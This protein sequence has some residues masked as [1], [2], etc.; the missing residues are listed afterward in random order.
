MLVL[1]SSVLIISCGGN[2]AKNKGNDKDHVNIQSKEVTY[3]SGQDTLKG[4]LYY[5]ANSDEKKPGI[6]VVHEWWGNNEYIQQRAKM[7]AE[8]GYTTFAADMYGNGKIVET[9][10]EANESST[11]VYSNPEILKRRMMA[12]HATLSKD[13]HT[14]SEKIAALGYCF[15][16]TVSLNAAALGVPLDA[17]I[18]FHGGLS[19]FKATPEMKDTKVLVLH[20]GADEFVSEDDVKNFKSQVQEADIQFV[21]K[22]YEEATHAFTNPNATEVGKK[23]NIPIAY[24]ERA[25]KASWQ[26]MKEFLSKH[27]PAEK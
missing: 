1:F 22:Q 14:D 18:S 17:A 8:L 15:G 13:P 2:S 24:N 5:D 26:D 7:L 10:K 9:P 21:F 11:A 25:D 27:F 4:F 19:G 12:A 6:I 16:G 20:G 3:M 23:Y